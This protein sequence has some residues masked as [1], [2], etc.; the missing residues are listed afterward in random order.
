MTAKQPDRRLGLPLICVLT[1]CVV[2]ALA[3]VAFHLSPWTIPVGDQRSAQQQQPSASLR[4]VNA[5]S[6]NEALPAVSAASRQ[7]LVAAYGNLPLAFEANQ[8]QTDPQV[9]YLA[10]GNGYTLFLTS[11]EAVFAMPVASRQSQSGQTGSG[12]A[13]MLLH[14]RLGPAK[15]LQ[16][17]RKQSSPAEQQ[18]SLVAS[19]RMQMLGANRKAQV[20]AENQQPGRTNYIIGRDPKKW[21]TNIPQYGQVRYR[22][23]YPGVD[24]AFH[25]ERQLEFDFLV[26]PHANPD[27]IALGFQGA[28]RMRADDSGGLVLTSAAGEIRLHKPI[29]Y[30]EK[31]GAREPVDARFVIKA[32]DEIAFALGPY[33]HSRRLVIDPSVLYST[34]LGGSKEDEGLGIAVDSSGNAYVTGQTDSTNFPGSPIKLGPGGS[35]DAFVTKLNSSGA[36]QF[37]TLLGGSGHEIGTAIAVDSTGIYVTGITD[38]TDF[39]STTG[40]AQATAP[41]KTGSHGNNSGFAAKLALG[42]AS[43]MWATYIGGNDSDAG[44]ALAVDATQ[45]VYV[46][47]E[48]F[49]S[50]S[51]PVTNPLPSG[52]ALNRGTG[53]GNNDGFIA[54]IKSDG[55]Q[56]LMLSYLGGSGGDLATG[57]AAD[58]SGN[59]YVSGETISTDLPVTVGAFQT[60]CGTDGNCNFNGSVSFDD[61]FVAKIT[62]ANTY[63]YLTYLGGE[64]VDDAV[65]ITADSSGNAYVTG[66]TQSTQF[67]IQAPLASNNTLVGV[68][69]VFVT[70]LN[71]TGIAP[72]IY[73]TYLGG[74]GSDLGLGIALD[75]SNNA[76]ITGLTSSTNFPK[77]S[78]TQPLFGGGNASA[79]DS[80]AFVS[81]LHL[82][83][84]SL[85]LPFSTYLGGAGDEDIL[86]GSLAVDALGNIYVTGDTGSSN[87]PLQSPADPTYGG[88][89]NCTILSTTVPCPDAFVTKF[90]PGAVA[91]DFQL[92]ATALSPASIAAGGSATSTI[93]ITSVGGFNSAVALS[94]SISPTVSHPPA[95][96]FNPAS[97][98]NGSGTSTLTVG[99]TA[100]S[101][102]LAPPSNR[103]PGL[104]YAIW[105]PVS[106][107]ALL[108][109]GFGSHKRKLLGFLLGC[110]VFSGLIFLVACGSSSGGGGGGGGG[111][112]TH[113]T[114]TITVTGT[115]GGATHS[116]PLTLTVH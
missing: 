54:K 104:F 61:A 116:T 73:S 106:G 48:T 19:L 37:T 98:A 77:A 97:V 93:T 115:G 13:D 87:F 30:Q 32:K 92:T 79:F 45:T 71:P 82:S 59:V 28:Q 38:S 102:L 15:I 46:A 107:L 68:Q 14:K 80:D 96:S 34:Y 24:V 94:C 55:S 69:N 5:G 112:T 50:T 111:G 7:R 72:L 78:P 9:K 95:C 89:G 103:R 33:D 88:G 75:S 23:M 42:G 29:A 114:Y 74:S 36:L 91:S 1:G 35:F 51:L 65:A 27:Q 84:T 6:G 44:F 21:H 40:S 10:R 113:G 60:G 2:L 57:V 49:S 83:G 100:A 58:P 20:A 81:E 4:L 31:D 108:G 66:L 85:S 64:S 109:A 62:A 101:A 53:P 8:G 16:Q 110:L 12:P 39:P 47:G 67:P 17:L 99:T 56:Y 52:G 41:T 76:Y 63:V 43:I 22:E 86:G 25:G 26:N 70:K 105:L 90:A 18:R 11:S 3:A